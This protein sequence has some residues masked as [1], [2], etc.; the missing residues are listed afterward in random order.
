MERVVR[1]VV[2]FVLTWLAVAPRSALAEDTFSIRLDGGITASTRFAAWDSGYGIS[3]DA[4][5]AGGGARVS[6]VV[7]ILSYTQKDLTPTFLVITPEIGVFCGR[8]SDFRFYYTLAMPSRLSSIN[9]P[10]ITPWYE[11]WFL[12]VRGGVEAE[13][14][15]R[16]RGIRA[17]AG[18]FGGL[19]RGENSRLYPTISLRVAVEFGKPAVPEPAPLAPD[20]WCPDGKTP[21]LPGLP[22]PEP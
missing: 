17:R 13:N 5:V 16:E 1:V 7:G 14:R 15:W 8:E 6:A 12:G 19:L 10:Y 20:R 9:A 3:W 18:A 22:C 4:F 11:Q 2:V 21:Q